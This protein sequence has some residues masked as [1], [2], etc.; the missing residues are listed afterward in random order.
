[1]SGV[2]RLKA[3]F[4]HAPR[5]AD[6]QISPDHP[7]K[8]ERGLWVYRMCG[9][10][11][12]FADPK[13]EVV[14]VEEADY[15]LLER[16]HTPQYIEILK[17][18]NSGTEV[19]VEMLHHGVG[20]AENPIFKGVYEFASLS[21]TAT[22]EAARRAAVDVESAFNPCGGWHHALP[23]RASGFCYVNDIVIA[24]DELRGMGKRVA[25]VDI[26]AH[27]GDAVQEAYYGDPTVLTISIHETGR[28]LF[29]WSGF[30]SEIGE[31]VGRGF[32]INIPLNPYSDDEV[33]L[34]L[35]RDIVMDALDIFG[36]DII[37]GQFGSD[38]LSTDPLTHLLLSN[39]GYIEAVKLLHRSFPRIVAL[40]GG[41]YNKSNVEKCLTLLWEELAGIK[42]EMGYGGALGG[43]FLGD[44][45]VQGAD[46]RDM[47]V[48]T[49]GTEKDE[50]LIR[51]DQLVAY[52]HKE[53]R[54]L[55]LAGA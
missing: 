21:T 24:I 4:I 32:N 6:F 18:A 11:G 30:E 38:G 14:T 8:P 12:L 10:R 1:M 16:F 44:S 49:S 9:E 28:T 47:P 13:V 20:A 52:Y 46:L 26:D 34:L 54:P 33:F 48:V 15:R 7:F 29:P 35:F 25:Y 31:S 41:G 19:D 22:I 5:L 36:P 40:G 55:L 53:I 23:D 17:R 42:P 43:V 27:H 39:N 2:Q 51:A 37:V 45:S 3:A 50:A